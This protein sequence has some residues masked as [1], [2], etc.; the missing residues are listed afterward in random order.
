MNLYITRRERLNALDDLNKYVQA[1]Q[2]TLTVKR[3]QR[4]VLWLNGDTLAQIAEAE[5][6]SPQAVSYSVHRDYKMI[7]EFT[8]SLQ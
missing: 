7:K 1:D 6:V 4:L 3:Y 8:S 5:G 2:S